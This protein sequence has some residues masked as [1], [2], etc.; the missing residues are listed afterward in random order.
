MAP[1]GLNTGA[2]P[3]HLYVSEKSATEVHGAGNERVRVKAGRGH[4]DPG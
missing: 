1:V 4:T 2:G 3:V